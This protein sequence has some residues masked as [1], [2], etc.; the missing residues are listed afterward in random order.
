MCE[1]AHLHNTHRLKEAVSLQ[2]KFQMVTLFFLLLF[3]EGGRGGRG[4]FFADLTFWSKSS[5]SLVLPLEAILIQTLLDNLTN[6]ILTIILAAET[7]PTSWSAKAMSILVRLD[8]TW[9]QYK[10]MFGHDIWFVHLFVPSVF[11]FCT[12]SVLVFWQKGYPDLAHNS[13]L[14]LV[15]LLWQNTITSL[16]K[17]WCKFKFS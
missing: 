6:L 11:W 14:Y 2:S 15:F 9:S 7:T 1:K 4:V 10:E 12:R 3:Y 17:I 8:F 5:C 13:I 16:V